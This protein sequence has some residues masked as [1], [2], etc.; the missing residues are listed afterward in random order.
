MV[1]DTESPR[2]VTR[3]SFPDAPADRPLRS[4]GTYTPWAD[5]VGRGFV[6]VTIT[7]A[8][9]AD[10][11]GGGAVMNT[12]ATAAALT[13]S[14]VTPMGARLGRPRCASRVNAPCRIG[15]SIT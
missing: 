2:K 10:D 1:H 6:D 5:V 12:T 14:T 3:G 15:C 11:V 8:A 7:G 4:I 9:E 13:P